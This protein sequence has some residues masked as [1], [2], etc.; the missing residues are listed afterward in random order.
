M[1]KIETREATDSAE[2]HHAW[3]VV[4]QLAEA[5]GATLREV[6]DDS[7]TGTTDA[8]AAVEPL[9]PGQLARDIAEIEQAATALRRAEPTLEPR[10]P[11]IEVRLET[12]GTGSVW[13][14][15]S[16]IWLTALV[17]VSSTVGAA[18]LLLG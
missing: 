1:P 2:W 10:A 15:V 4:A 5:R 17:V 14:L 16:V 18:M 12:R 13:V 11:D 6:P 3:K 7:A 8:A 9:A